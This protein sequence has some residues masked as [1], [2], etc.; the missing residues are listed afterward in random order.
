MPRFFLVFSGGVLAVLAV[1][2]LETASVLRLVGGPTVSFGMRIAVIAAD[3]GLVAPALL[4]LATVMGIGSLLLGLVGGRTFVEDLQFVR[5]QPALRTRAAAVTPL[6]I[7]GGFL[8]LVCAAQLGRVTTGEG[9]PSVSGLAAAL[10]SVL[11]TLAIGVLVFALLPPVWRL[12][13]RV[14]RVWPPIMDPIV[15][16]AFAVALVT[17]GLAAGMATGDSGGAGGLPAIGVFAVLTRPELDLRPVVYV[18]AAVGLCLVGGQLLMFDPR[19]KVAR[20][21]VLLA[22]AELALTLRASSS[23]GR[24]PAV[25]DVV[26]LAP[27]G[28][29]SLRFLRRLSDRDHDGYSAGFG[30]GDCDDHDPHVNP[31]ATDV[32]GNGI[33]EDCSG[34]DAPVIAPEPVPEPPVV[35]ETPRRT[36]NV[37]L[38]TID[39]L[40]FDLGFTGYPRPVTPNLDRLAAKGTVF[41]RA[42]STASYTAKAMGALMMGKYTSEAARNW[43][44]YTSYTTANTFFAKRARDAGTFNLAGH[45]HY[46]FQWPTGYQQGFDVYDASAIPPGMGDNDSSTTSDRLSDLAIRMLSRSEIKRL[47]ERRF[48]AWFHYFDPHSQYVHHEGAPDFAHMPGGPPARALYDEEVWYTDKHVGRVL[49]FIASQPWGPDTAVVVTADHGEAFSDAHGVKTH[50][51]EIWE[52]LVRVPLVVYVP[53]GGASHVDVKRSHVDVA[54]TILELLGAPSVVP[55]QLRGRSLL[56]DVYAKPGEPHEERDVYLDMPEGPYNDM[57]RALITGP[58]PGMKLLHLGG[59]RYQLFDLATDPGETTDLSGDPAR[60]EPLRQRM[61]AFRARL[62]EIAVTGA[63]R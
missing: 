18:F 55:G 35:A 2:V 40:R 54:P 24:E 16:G 13:A 38:F 56:A 22:V 30:G 23:L 11:A 7:L 12:V 57:R 59:T 46:Y 1:A 52:S 10:G 53:D 26:K 8:V 62:H 3:A 61:E 9:A 14:G 60:F 43:D 15:T 48:F 50:G 4:A 37:V 47:G 42:Y 29:P 36:F 17:L 21:G 31:D 51:H 44:H 5:S 45:C 25:A 34:A 33:D 6:A 58:S 27:L 39:T 19:A 63:K 41:E 49:D 20:F 32:P 28:G